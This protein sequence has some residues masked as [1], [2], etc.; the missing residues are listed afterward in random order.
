M[1]IIYKI[2]NRDIPVALLNDITQ[3]YEVIF[4]SQDASKIRDRIAAKE[5]VL[6]L[7]AHH[8][9]LLVGFKIGYAKSN[10]IFYSWLGGVQPPFRQYGIA[11]ELM[12][13]QHQWASDNNFKWVETK[14]LNRWKNM[15]ILNLKHGFEIFSTHNDNQNGQLKIIMRKAL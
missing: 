10:T 15:L 9:S 11:S 14:T 1:S 12:T 13:M 5:Q 7:T 3:L 2:W 4:E 6:I 8:D